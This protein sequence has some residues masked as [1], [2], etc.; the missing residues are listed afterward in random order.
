ALRYGADPVGL[1]LG[2]S[3][4]VPAV[5]LAAWRA[6]PD[7]DPNAPALSPDDPAWD[8]WNPWTAREHEPDD[9]ESP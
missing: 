2:L 6:R 8:A 9:E 1:L 7:A 3:L 5:V 4:I